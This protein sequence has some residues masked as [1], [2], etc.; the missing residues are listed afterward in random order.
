MGVPASDEDGYALPYDDPDIGDPEGLLR[1]ISAWFL[2]DDPKR[3]GPR[4]SSGAFSPA[5]TPYYGMS[6]DREAPMLADG[7]EP[8]AMAR[9]ARFGLARLT[10]GGVRA[11]G[12]MVGGTP[13]PDNPYHADVWWQAG[14][15]NFPKK[16]QK[17]L[18]AQA[19]I[20]R[21]PR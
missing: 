17:A 2:V 6:V 5:S 21:M 20:L 10:A 11:T 13:Q 3:A 18:L 7:H 16:K 15:K 14:Q 1:R 12:F 4:L 19:E 9:E 8:V